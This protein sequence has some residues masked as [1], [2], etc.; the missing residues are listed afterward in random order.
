[1]KKKPPPHEERRTHKGYETQAVLQ[2]AKPSSGSV[3]GYDLRGN[4]A[5]NLSD[6]SPSMGSVTRRGTPLMTHSSQRAVRGGYPD[7]RGFR[8][9][10]RHDGV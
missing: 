7:E 6:P 5:E 3:S 9:R 10:S 8:F 4:G 2:S 1:M